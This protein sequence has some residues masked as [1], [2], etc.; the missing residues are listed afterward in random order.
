[1]KTLR[2]LNKASLKLIT[3]LLLFGSLSG[4]LFLA[5]WEAYAESPD[6]DLS[7]Y[8][9][10]DE[11]SLLAPHFLLESDSTQLKS[12]F[13]PKR[14]K[15]KAT[16][17][18]ILLG[19]FGVHRIYLGTSA[20]VPVAYSLTLGGGLG[21]LPLLDAIAIIKS[22]DLEGFTDNDRVIMWSRPKGE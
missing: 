10:L 17:L 2:Q 3:K 20:N 18:T 13:K 19:H 1:M 5:S 16:L 14:R 4:L 7:K 22:K 12:A 11:E 6:Q 9:E 15:L 21:L 8:V